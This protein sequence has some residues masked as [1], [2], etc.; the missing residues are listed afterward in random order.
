[1]QA[2]YAFREAARLRGDDRE[3]LGHCALAA[4]DVGLFEEALY[5]AGRALALGGT[6]LPQVSS[7][8]AQAVAKDLK[9]SDGTKTRRLLEKAHALLEDYCAAAPTSAVHWEARLH[10]EQHCGGAGGGAAGAAGV[11]RTLR[12]QLA[13]YRNHA[14]WTSDAATLGAVVEVAAQLVEALLEGG[15]GEDGGELREAKRLVDELQH[16]ASEKL[17]ATEGCEQLRML[18]AKIARHDDD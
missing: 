8:V 9:A 15:G 18:Q 4:L 12:L 14:P 10:L 6:P 2:L 17:A 11:K 1:V 7:L 5:H 16:A 3:L 13:A